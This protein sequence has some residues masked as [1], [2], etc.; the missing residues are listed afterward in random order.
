M[1]ANIDRLDKTERLSQTR[2]RRASWTDPGL[3]VKTWK[4]THIHRNNL[5]SFCMFSGEQHV[6]ACKERS[7]HVGEELFLCLD[8]ANIKIRILKSCGQGKIYLLNCSIDTVFVL[9]SWRDSHCDQMLKCFRN[10][11]HQR[12]WNTVL[13][14]EGWNLLEKETHKTNGHTH[15]SKTKTIMQCSSKTRGNLVLKRGKPRRFSNNGFTERVNTTL[16]CKN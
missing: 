16:H 4:R 14:H 2:A 9:V 1:W 3:L 8:K 5:L 7:Q 10:I 11:K 12:F 15:R 13:N 6:F